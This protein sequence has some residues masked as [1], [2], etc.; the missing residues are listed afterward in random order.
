VASLT[1]ED[2]D[3]KGKVVSL[4]RHKT[5]TVSINPNAA[6]KLNGHFRD[7]LSSLSV[8]VDGFEHDNY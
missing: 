7:Y 4:R 2:I 6:H 8:S 5:G 1:A 3:W